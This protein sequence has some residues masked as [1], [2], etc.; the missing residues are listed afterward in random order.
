MRVIFIRPW[1]AR[2]IMALAFAMFL[3]GRLLGTSTHD[4]DF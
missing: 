4:T 3:A 1:Q 2:L